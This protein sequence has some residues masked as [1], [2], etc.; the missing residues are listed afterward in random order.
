MSFQRSR[1]KSGIKSLFGKFRAEF[2]PCLGQLNRQD[3]TNEHLGFR[4]L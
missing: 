2:F 4:K 1:F 3:V